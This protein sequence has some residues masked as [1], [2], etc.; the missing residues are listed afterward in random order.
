M[1]RNPISQTHHKKDFKLEQLLSYIQET[2]HNGIWKKLVWSE[3][4]DLFNEA[5]VDSV[6]RSLMVILET[7][8]QLGKIPSNIEL[9]RS[10]D[11]VY[12]R[13]S[14]G[15]NGPFNQNP[16]VNAEQILLEIV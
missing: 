2:P 4:R 16:L 7:M 9:Q 11:G 15:K 12:F 1:Y 8:V 5:T 3:D 6:D 14:D 13:L 10:I